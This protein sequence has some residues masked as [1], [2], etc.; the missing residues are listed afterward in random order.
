LSDELSTRAGGAVHVNTKTTK[1]TKTT[2]APC[3]T[4]AAPLAEPA[5][6]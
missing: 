3:G 5:V 2:K 4:V 6:A 1:D